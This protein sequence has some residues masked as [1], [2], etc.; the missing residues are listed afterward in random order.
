LWLGLLISWP[1]MFLGDAWPYG[2][3][4]PNVKLSGKPPSEEL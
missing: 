1:I 4:K 2:G 3:M